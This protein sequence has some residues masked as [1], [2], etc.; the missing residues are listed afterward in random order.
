MRPRPTKAARTGRL[1]GVKLTLTPSHALVRRYRQLHLRS[2]SAPYP[3]PARP[4]RHP[5]KSGREVSSPRSSSRSALLGSFSGVCFYLQRL[6]DGTARTMTATE[7]GRRSCTF[8][9]APVGTCWRQS[10]PL[11]LLKETT[12]LC[13]LASDSVFCLVHLTPLSTWGR[14]TDQAYVLFHNRQ[15]Q[16]ALMGRPSDQIQDSNTLPR[17]RVCHGLNDAP[18]QHLGPWDALTGSP[19]T[20][21]QPPSPVRPMQRSGLARLG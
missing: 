16:S 19:C 17:R 5:G 4:G 11:V 3:R 2:S 7:G 18:Q 1:Y 13:P 6:R 21:R 12:K 8:G 10:T 15:D 14:T 20:G 9:A